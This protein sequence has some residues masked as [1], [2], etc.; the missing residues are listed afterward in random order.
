[1]FGRRSTPPEPLDPEVAAAEKP[2]KAAPP[3]PPPRRRIRRPRGGLLSMMSGLLSFAVVLGGVVVFGLIALHHEVEKAGPLDADKVVMIPKG[4]GTAEIASLL[5][6]EQVIDNPTLFE[7]YSY[8]SR[9][10]GDLKAGEYLFKARTSIDDAIDTLIGPQVTIR[11]RFAPQLIL[12]GV[13]GVSDSQKSP[14]RISL[15]R[16]VR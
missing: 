3:P 16:S 14:L 8:L 9:R 5:A 13:P 15:R 6:K 10:K 11:G 2:A 7:L 4:K 1:M 12:P